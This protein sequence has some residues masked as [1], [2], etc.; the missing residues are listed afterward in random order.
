MVSPEIIYTKA[1]KMEKVGCICIYIHIYVTIK[2]KGGYQFE[3][4]E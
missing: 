4:E 1:M 2:R 3:R